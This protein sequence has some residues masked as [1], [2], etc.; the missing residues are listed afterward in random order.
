MNNYGLYG[1]SSQNGP[2]SSNHTYQSK[3]AQS[4]SPSAHSKSSQSKAGHTSKSASSSAGHAQQGYLSNDYPTT[5]KRMHYNCK[6]N[7]Q[8]KSLS[9][10]VQQI[11]ELIKLLRKNMEYVQR[12]GDVMKLKE[13][14][15]HPL[16]GKPKQ[17]YDICMKQLERARATETASTG[18]SSHHPRMS[19]QEHSSSSS[20]HHSYHHTAHNLNASPQTRIDFGDESD[21]RYYLLQ[22]DYRITIDRHCEHIWNTLV[23]NVMK[24]QAA[25]IEQS[26]KKSKDKKKVKGKEQLVFLCPALVPSDISSKTRFKKLIKNP[27]T[28]RTIRRRI[29]SN[30]YNPRDTR[31]PI[32]ARD[33]LECC[34][35]EI[36]LQVTGTPMHQFGTQQLRFV[37]SALAHS[38]TIDPKYL[39]QLP[40]FASG[41]QGNSQS[42]SALSHDALGRIV[43]GVTSTSK[44]TKKKDSKKNKRKRADTEDTSKKKKSRKSKPKGSPSTPCIFFLFDIL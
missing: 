43:S 4:S 28:L 29:L 27:V 9:S 24:Y 25:T 12:E 39:A 2:P 21:L 40:G 14:I 26:K 33:L 17:F 34:H 44:D 15:D 11:D 35:N 20:H 30:Y 8:Q 32:W 10:F 1:S 31:T 16:V 7:K 22:P 3:T 13:A 36:L 38:Q 41:Q 23:R 19:P 37:S 18:R 5:Y 42:S 6:L